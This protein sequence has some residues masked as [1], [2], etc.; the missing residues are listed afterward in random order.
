MASAWQGSPEVNSHIIG[1]PGFPQQWNLPT[2]PSCLVAP[3]LHV[4]GCCSRTLLET[5]R[6]LHRVNHDVFVCVADLG[7]FLWSWNWAS[8][9]LLAYGMQQN[10][11]LGLGILNLGIN[12]C[13]LKFLFS[14][15]LCWIF[16]AAR[17]FFYLGRAGASHCSGFSCGALALGHVGWAVLSQNL[18]A[19]LVLS[20]HTERDGLNQCTCIGRW[21]LFHCVTREVQFGHK[22]VTSFIPKLLRS[23][24]ILIIPP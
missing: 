3:A 21:V 17:G 9:A 19:G 13:I 8:E 16:V 11:G 5:G 20:G 24:K 4:M 15:W 12:V 6:V 7:P 1:N 2:C 10:S 22:N 18:V 23:G 14:F